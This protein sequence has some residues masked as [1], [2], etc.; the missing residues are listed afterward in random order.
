MRGGGGEAALAKYGPVKVLGSSDENDESRMMRLTS[1]GTGFERI[2]ICSHSADAGQAVSTRTWD[3]SELLG[4]SNAGG[5][6]LGVC[7]V[8]MDFSI[9][10]FA[11]SPTGHGIRCASQESSEAHVDPRLLFRV[12]PA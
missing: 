7:R 2:C 10:A 11:K 12:Q 3:F 4:G 6:E 1:E 8:C 9:A 5:W